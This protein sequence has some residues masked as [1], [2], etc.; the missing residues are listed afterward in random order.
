M[1]KR[2]FQTPEYCPVCGEDVPA[3]A[4]ACPGCGA[5]ETSGW[6]TEAEQYEEEPFDYDRVIEVEFRGR[7][8]RTSGLT[9]FW[10][11]VAILVLAGLLWSRFFF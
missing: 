10:W 1:A 5:D 7:P 4:L 8:R 11:I 9:R 3:R 6:K 2:K